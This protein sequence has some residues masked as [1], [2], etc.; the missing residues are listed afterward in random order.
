[1]SDRQSSTAQRITAA[2]SS[3]PG[4]EVGPHRFGGV[5]FRVGRREL[6]HLHGDRIAD[7]PFPRRV[8]DELIATGRARVHH[9]LPDSGW[10]TAPI[11]D[12]RGVDDVIELFRLSYQRA[13]DSRA[14]AT[15]RTASSFDA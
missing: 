3:W 6:G 1:M 12:Q 8:R 15:S 5:E 2:V 11:S 4:V 13:R 10:V 14:R 7:L 9:V